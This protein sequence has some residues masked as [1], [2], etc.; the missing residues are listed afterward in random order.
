MKVLVLG[1]TGVISREIVKLLID[2]D[3]EVT[4]YN[5]GSRSLPVAGKVR[6]II[7]DRADREG[8]ESSARRVASVFEPVRHF[9][10]RRLLKCVTRRR[11]A[12]SACAASEREP[13][14]KERSK[15]CGV[16]HRGEPAFALVSRRATAIAIRSHR[17]SSNDRTAARATGSSRN[18]SCRS[19]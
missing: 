19:T 4:L 17:E 7:G 6:Q 11:E 10:P 5:R 15:R 13:A 3:H 12:S 14:T 9:N 8:F 18:D 2:K 1:G 16:H